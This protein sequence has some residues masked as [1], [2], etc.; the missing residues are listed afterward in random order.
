MCNIFL[1][2]SGGSK[3]DH[4]KQKLRVFLKKKTFF[5]FVTKKKTKILK[6]KNVASFFSFFP[7]EILDW[8]F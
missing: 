7:W 4:Q 3:L 5:L 2:S 1:S 8:D 6:S